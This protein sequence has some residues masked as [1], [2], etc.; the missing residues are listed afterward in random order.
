[1]KNEF[2]N[3][4]AALAIQQAANSVESI[5]A[6]TGLPEDKKE[7]VE[8]QVSRVLQQ[9]PLLKSKRVWSAVMGV[10]TAILSAPPVQTE[11]ARFF[12]TV[13]DPVYVPLVTAVL[14]AAL[15]TLS[16]KDDGR[17]LRS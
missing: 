13:L 5:A 2:K 9:D 17:P 3:I 15:A 14:A 6:A 4:I 8:N 1:M 7:F 12:G 11:L 16:K 10:L